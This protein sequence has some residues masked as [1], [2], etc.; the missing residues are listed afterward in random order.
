ISHR[1]LGDPQRAGELDKEAYDG[2]RHVLGDNHPYT[3]YSASG[4]GRDLRDLGRFEE[5]RRWLE[6]AHDVD[7]R[8]LGPDRPDPLPARHN[9]RAA[10]N[11]AVTYRR[12]AQFDQADQ[13][14]A[15]TLRMSNARLGPAHTDSLLV[16]MTV[17]TIYS[18]RGLD[19]RARMAGERAV[20]GLSKT[21]GP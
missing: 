15:E 16:L 8:S 2:R 6:L 7:V 3:A 14:A 4:Y 20:S 17:A 13:L 1:V 18:A 11:L 9:L 12:L 5:S 21:L 19:D 10:K